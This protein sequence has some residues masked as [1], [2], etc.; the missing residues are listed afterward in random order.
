MGSYNDLIKK[1][2]S[3]VLTFGLPISFSIF[4]L[5]PELINIF[6]GPGY[7]ELL[8]VFRL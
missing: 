7:E 3:F 1:S 5:A 2:M 8:F 4:L 6:A